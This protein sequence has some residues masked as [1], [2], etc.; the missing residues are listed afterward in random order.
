M[1][2]A[3]QK[4]PQPRAQ[5]VQPC[6]YRFTVNQYHQMLEKGIF[7]SGDRVE[8]L[9]GWII[10][11]MTQ[12]PPHAVAVELTRD[13]LRAILPA[14]WH[15]RDQKPMTTDESEPEPDLAVVR[16]TVRSFT[17]RHPTTGEVALVVEVADTTLENDRDRKGR[18]YARAGIPVYWIIN[19]KEDIVEVYTQ[20]KRG[21][22]PEYRDRTDYTL[23]DTISVVLNGKEVGSVTVRD[24][25]P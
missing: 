14:D 21:R 2:V 1:S 5:A 10:E 23:K 19:L 9:E 15:V 7:V 8:L 4:R 24:L 12:K 3:T 16:G 6:G 11:K 17:R 22:T 18:I 13:A 20:P 25:L